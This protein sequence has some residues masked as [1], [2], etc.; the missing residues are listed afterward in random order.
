VIG[1]T[2]GTGLDRLSAYGWPAFLIALPQLLGEVPQLRLQ[3]ATQRSFGF[4]FLFLHGLSIADGYW[5]NY[6]ASAL[7][8]VVLYLLGW[9][10]LQ[11]WWRDAEVDPRNLSVLAQQPTNA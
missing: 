5:S 6:V 4:L 3:S 9:R 11:L 10:I 1:P 7:L 2:L 8:Q